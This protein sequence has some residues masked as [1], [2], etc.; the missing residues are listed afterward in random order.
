MRKIIILAFILSFLIHGVIYCVCSDAVLF[1]MSEY[2]SKIHGMLQIKVNEHFAQLVE[3][4]RLDDSIN[5]P[6]DTDVLKQSVDELVDR[7]NVTDAL[8]DSVQSLDKNGVTTEEIEAPQPEFDQSH[9]KPQRDFSMP[10]EQLLSSAGSGIMDD[11]AISEFVNVPVRKSSGENSFIGDIKVD[12]GEVFDDDRGTLFLAASSNVQPAYLSDETQTRNVTI[13]PAFKSALV[14]QGESPM[15]TIQIGEI[16]VAEGQTRIAGELADCLSADCETYRREGDDAVYAKI[17]ITPKNAQNMH[18]IPKNLLFL[19]DVSGSIS[20]DNIE[21]IRKDV[22]SCLE[23]L[24]QHDGFNVVLFNVAQRQLFDSFQSVS[25]DTVEQALNFINKIGGA[26]QT[27]IYN[28]LMEVVPFFQEGE[29]ILHIVFISDAKPTQ[30]TRSFRKIINDFTQHRIGNI[31]FFTYEVGR[32]KNK[33]LLDYLA[34]ENRGKA[35]HK[36]SDNDESE[37]LVNF[38]EP[39]GD[40]V[41]FDMKIDEIKGDTRDVF[42]RLL[43]HVY[44]NKN[45]EIYV[46]LDREGT[47]SFDVSGIDGTGTRKELN[48]AINTAGHTSSQDDEIMQKWAHY[49]LFELISLAFRE[50]MTDQLQAEMDALRE[51]YGIKIARELSRYLK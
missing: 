11:S 34:Y 29:R 16:S 40:P 24:N 22:R 12:T 50:G 20:Q 15:S 44:L 4:H 28:A 6:D 1:D 30:G 42:P 49:K 33:F 32:A 17:T 2:A 46:R 18:A 51:S 43:N 39:Y 36:E 10:K 3:S 8:E 21:G 35:F 13:E 27:N 14:F 19:V 5:V 48:C 31:A 9:L 7:Q 38:I 47:F 37:A 41:L 45:I 23:Q 25:D 26:Q